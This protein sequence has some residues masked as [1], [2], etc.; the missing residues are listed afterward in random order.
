M[1]KHRVTTP[2]WLYCEPN[3]TPTLLS[4]IQI[5]L[6]K[7]FSKTKTKK[8]NLVPYTSTYVEFNN[9]NGFI[10]KTCPILA[11]ELTRLNL[12]DRLE[13]VAFISVVAD[14]EFPAHIDVGVDVALNIPLLNCDG[15]YTVWYDGQLAQGDDANRY[16]YALG[17]NSANNA[18]AGDI[19]N[20]I[21]ID[22]CH[23]NKPL[24]INVN[25][26]HR[27]VTTHNKFRVAASLRFGS[28]PL[29]A[30][31]MLWPHLQSMDK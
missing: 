21:E 3:L 26:L 1:Y 13:T 22:R 7:V 27:P 30:N 10:T 9:I 14:H 11:K 17:S 16:P 18:C 31:N 8:D 5:E 19:S 28:A 2:D 29:D 20:L 24:W 23:A 4:A 6:Q 15:T 25:V 12:L